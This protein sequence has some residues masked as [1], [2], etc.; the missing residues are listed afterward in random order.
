MHVQCGASY[1][2]SFKCMFI[3]EVAKICVL[4]HIL[5]AKNSIFFWV[6]PQLLGVENL[7]FTI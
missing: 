6:G 5:S 1:N 7:N 2:M 3:A 4:D